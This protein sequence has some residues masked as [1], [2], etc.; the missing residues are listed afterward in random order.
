VF[1]HEVDGKREGGHHS[2][3]RARFGRAQD[4]LYLALR[5]R[6]VSTLLGGWTPEP[7]QLEPLVASANAILQRQRVGHTQAERFD[8]SLAK[9]CIEQAAALM[10]RE[11]GLDGDVDE[12]AIAHLTDPRF[13]ALGYDLEEDDLEAFSMGDATPSWTIDA[14]HAELVLRR[15]HLWVYLAGPLHDVPPELR[16]QTVERL[17]GYLVARNVPFLPDLLVFARAEGVDLDRIESRA[18]LPVVDRFWTTPTG[19]PWCDLLRR[20]LTYAGALDDVRR[21]EVL[22]DAVEAGSLVRHTVD[23]ESRER[24]REAF[25]TPLFPMVLVANEV[26]QEG[27]DL[28]HHCRRVIHH[29]L[30]WNPAQ[31]EQRVGRVD[32]LGSLVQRLRDRRPET[33]LDVLLPLI[34]NTIDERLERTVRL[35]ERWLEFLLGAAPRIDEYGL[36]DDPQQPLPLAFAEALRIELGPTTRQG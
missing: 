25:N 23:G 1:E 21:R 16:V 6:Y 28:H 20:F 4:A 15:E 13:V 32:R 3:L 35:R 11:L 9:R 30:A 10:M 2:R 19:R 29:D 7:A 27:L 12:Q 5:E 34:E 22:D 8:W 36:A 18:L 31:L 14:E 24:L 33:T 17:A 26:M